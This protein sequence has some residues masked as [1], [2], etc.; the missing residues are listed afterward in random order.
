M[1]SLFLVPA[2]IW[3]WAMATRY[4]LANRLAH[5]AMRV[6]AVAIFAGFIAMQTVIALIGS[7]ITGIAGIADTGQNAE[8]KEHHWDWAT[9]WS[10]PKAETLAIFV[11]GLFGY[12][13]DTPNNMMPQFQDAYRGGVYW[14][15]IGRDPGLDQFLDA[16]G[17]GT[18][19]AGFMR[20]TGGTNYCGILL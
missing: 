20:F 6:G 11:P 9:Q 1:V 15:G 5:S 10:L 7:S 8:T 12:K 16:G 13:M 4:Q 18:P 19:P 17:T 2:C 3:N 14:G